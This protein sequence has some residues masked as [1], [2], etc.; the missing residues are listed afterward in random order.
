[1]IILSHKK[2]FVNPFCIIFVIFRFLFCL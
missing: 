2:A 1:L